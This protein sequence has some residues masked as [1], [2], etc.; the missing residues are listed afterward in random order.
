MEYEVHARTDVGNVRERNEDSH[1]VDPGNGVFAVADGMGGGLGGDVASQIL[2]ET[3]QQEADR[4]ARE[5]AKADLHRD[6]EGR[7]RVLELMTSV[8]LRA[9]HELYN[10][11]QG[12]MGTTGDLVLIADHTALLAHVGD[13]RVYLVRDNQLRQLTTDHTYAEEGTTED[14]PEGEQTHVLT[15]CIGTDPHVD[16]DTLFVE[17]QPDDRFLLCTDGLTTQVGRDQ[18]SDLADQTNPERL[19]DRLVEL[20]RQR[21]G[22][23]NT[24]VAVVDVPD[25]A[26]N[27][28]DERDSI[29][30]TDKVDILQRVEAFAGLPDRRILQLL[31]YVYQQDFAE[32][33]RLI[34]RGDEEAAMYIIVAG[35]VVVRRDGDEVT[36]LGPGEH[37]GEMAL[38]DSPPRSADVVA[39][40]TVRTL[41]ISP[42]DFRSMVAGSDLEL[43]N[44]ILLNMLRRCIDR[45]RET[46]DAL[47]LDTSGDESSR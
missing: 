29:A 35:E 15:R 4:L 44:A 37:V 21:G 45:L 43:G 8:L 18:L 10:T 27:E 47:M 30:T 28:F 17:L 32:G 3:I 42:E 31:R 9:N 24:T 33:E 38:V 26:S 46:T 2:V 5:A 25:S 7:E 1:L 12:E 19:A 40:E 22:V 39:T 11:G 36:R 6:V 13:S 16:I 23:D 20:A 34:T 14:P 41:T